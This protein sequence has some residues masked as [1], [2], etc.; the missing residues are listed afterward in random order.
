MQSLRKWNGGIRYLSC[1]IDLFSEYAWVFPLKDR[2]KINFVNCFQKIILK[3]R[4]LNKI[5]VD[6]GGIFYKIFFKRFLKNNN[7]EMYSTFNEG[8]F[9]ITE[10]FIT[11]LKKKIFQHMTA[12]SK[13]V[14][15]YMLDNIV[16]S[17]NNTVHR[18]IKMKQIEVTSDCYAE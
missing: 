16:K 6:Q 17:Y 10:R 1:A 15:F 18:T 2:R 9:V 4:K 14:Y 11:N 8:K 13:N 7:I 5:W 3:G 12:I